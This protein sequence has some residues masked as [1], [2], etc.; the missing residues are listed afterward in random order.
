MLTERQDLPTG[1]YTTWYSSC[2]C[3]RYVRV[4]E[5]SNVPHIFIFYTQSTTLL[6]LK[7]YV[8]R[9]ID[10]I[11]PSEDACLCFDGRSSLVPQPRVY[12]NKHFSAV[13]HTIYVHEVHEALV[14]RVDSTAR[15][16]HMLQQQRQQE[17]SVPHDDAFSP[18]RG[19][20]MMQRCSVT[21]VDGMFHVSYIRVSYVLYE[22]HLQVRAPSH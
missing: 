18:A 8:R 13:R 15:N 17:R 5:R 20:N 19:V 11:S 10:L 21:G 3:T 6:V 9:R 16:V 4:K 2:V 1:W 22:I 12:T 7:A 14:M